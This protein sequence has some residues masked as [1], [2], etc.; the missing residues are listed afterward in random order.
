[1]FLDFIFAPRFHQLKTPWYF[2]YLNKVLVLPK[3]YLH[4]MSIYSSWFMT[5]TIKY[6]RC[7]TGMLYVERSQLGLEFFSL[8]RMLRLKKFTGLTETD[9]EGSIIGY[10]IPGGLWDRDPA[11][12]DNS[13][14]LEED[15]GNCDEDPDNEWRGCAAAE[16]EAI[17]EL[18]YSI[19]CNL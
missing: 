17:W 10:F 9:R 12:R 2:E 15:D 4:A 5:L 3:I 13:T 19:E 14:H 7:I 18:E 11:S 16:T 8:V 6:I 1:M